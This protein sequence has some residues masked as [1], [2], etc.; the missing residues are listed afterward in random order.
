MLLVLD[1]LPMMTGLER[2]ELRR[3]ASHE[4][5]HAV[6][7]A[8]LGAPFEYLSISEDG[9][10]LVQPSITDEGDGAY[11]ELAGKHLIVAYAGVEA[12][13][14]FHPEQPL[15]QIV[16]CAQDDADKVRAM[17][18]EFGFTTAEQSQAKEQATALV[19]QLRKEIQATAD[20]LLERRTLTFGEVKTLLTQVV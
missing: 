2:Q 16:A 1:G 7:S 18:E 13:R 4:A 19:Q 6:V 3:T 9:T 20:A 12:Q 5:G 11:R 14:M 17:T 8:H 15:W 10:G